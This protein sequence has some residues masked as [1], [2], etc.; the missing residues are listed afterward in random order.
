ME[1]YRI[2]FLICFVLIVVVNLIQ[3]RFILTPS[4]YAKE[5]FDYYLQGDMKIYPDVSNQYR[6]AENIAPQEFSAHFIESDITAIAMLT[7]DRLSRLASLAR[8]WS[9][10][11]S[12]VLFLRTYKQPHVWTPSD[13]LARISK[14]F[15]FIFT[16]VNIHMHIVL[17]HNSFNR[18]PMNELRNIAWKFVKTPKIFI[19]DVDF[20]PSADIHKELLKVKPELWIMIKERKAA[21]VISAWDY[22]CV[23]G[24]DEETCEVYGPMLG[25][26]DSQLASNMTKWVRAT[27]P[28]PVEYRMYYEPYF[29]ASS[30]I[31]KYDE[32]FTIGHDKTEHT[33][34]LVASG[35]QFWV[36]PRAYIAHIPHPPSVSHS[37]SND[38]YSYDGAWSQ[39]IKFVRRVYRQY[40]Y[41]RYCDGIQKVPHGNPFIRLIRPYI[42]YL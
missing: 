27:D 18:F 16:R 39:W 30:E 31:P 26:H 4:E 23:D 40:G 33:Y 38:Y 28:Y 22:G 10:P 36:L 15:P 5:N 35:I 14:K 6:I 1:E 24:Y 32:L 19:L 2:N 8:R 37:L 21:L 7:P 20:I 12:F 41:H 13:I 17:V 9:G 34:E 3:Y 29:I 25:N 11:I 42:C